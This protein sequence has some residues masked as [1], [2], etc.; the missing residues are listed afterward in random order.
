MLGHGLEGELRLPHPGEL[1]R[2]P[3]LVLV[4][5]G[6]NRPLGGAQRNDDLWRTARGDD[7]AST[8]SPRGLPD[9]HLDEPTSDGNE[10]HPP[11]A[12]R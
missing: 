10:P 11:Q 2:E 9:L 6:A 5:Q 3:T 7:D 4:E 8:T 1:A 12:T